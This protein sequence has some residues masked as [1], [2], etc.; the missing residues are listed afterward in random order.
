MINES[1]NLK[2]IKEYKNNA[3]LH[4]KEQIQHIKNS[5]KEFGYADDIAIDE[6]DTIIY[7]HGRF[8]ALKELQKENWDLKDG[9][10]NDLDY[11]AIPVKRLINY[12]DEQK[13]AY[14]LAHNQT[15]L[16]SGFDMDIVNT[17]LGDILDINM[18]DFGFDLDLEDEAKEVEEDEDFSIND[19]EKHLLKCPSCGFI[20]ERKAFE[21]YEDTE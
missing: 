12:T 9:N 7:G 14:I 4:P 20:N 3:K 5:I 17:E 10:G 8:K 6:N 1:I 2:D 13:R 16:S 21:N 18:S 15:T 19:I 11:N